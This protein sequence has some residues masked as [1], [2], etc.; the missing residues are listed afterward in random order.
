MGRLPL[1]SWMWKMP[2][3]ATEVQTRSPCLSGRWDPALLAVTEPTAR[4]VASGVTCPAARSTRG[5]NGPGPGGSH[6][7]LC[8]AASL[9]CVP[10][11]RCSPASV[12]DVGR[13]E[14]GKGPV[15]P[16][17]RPLRVGC[18]TWAGPWAPL[19]G[20]PHLTVTHTWGCWLVWEGDDWAAVLPAPT[21]GES[22]AA[23]SPGMVFIREGV[24]ALGVCRRVTRAQ[25]G[26]CHS[27]TAG[28][29]V[30]RGSSLPK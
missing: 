18:V 1:G 24:R 7:H 9:L 14:R 5:T 16:W 6:D 2:G 21:W 27:A 19:A 10:P 26:T 4:R 20:P 22:K 25:T 23:L 11:A 28:Q 12:T 15:G 8:P 3:A 17:P 29:P 30:P 13:W